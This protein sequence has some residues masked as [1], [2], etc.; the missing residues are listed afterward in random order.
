VVR[1]KERK[2]RGRSK[3]VRVDRDLSDYGEV[4][5]LKWERTGSNLVG[6][7]LNEGGKR[8]VLKERQTKG[9]LTGKLKDTCW[10]LALF[11]ESPSGSTKSEE[12]FSRRQSI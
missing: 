11:Q 4:A 7:T 9:V 5:T 2:K 6:E 12:V 3:T 8:T 10:W 1:S